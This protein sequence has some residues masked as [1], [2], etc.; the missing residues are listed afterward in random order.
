MKNSLKLSFT[1]IT[2]VLVS[3]CSAISY[4]PKVSLDVSQK[5]I[6]KNVV[7]K[8][9]KD[10]T[11]RK[12]KQNPFAGASVTNKRAMSNDLALEVTNPITLDFSQNAVFNTVKRKM[13]SP[14]YIITG[15]INKYRGVTKLTNFGLIIAC[16]IIGTYS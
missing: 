13:T 16:S 7:V 1:I 10:N 15:E 12:D 8:L 3:S 11:Y 2:L 4:S 14:D 9:F 5:T 6:A